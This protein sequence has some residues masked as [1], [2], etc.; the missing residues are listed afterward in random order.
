MNRLIHALK[1]TERSRVRPVNDDENP[2]VVS[3]AAMRNALDARQRAL[4]E[5]VSQLQTDELAETL[6][7][8]VADGA[9]VAAEQDEIMSL[10]NELRAQLDDVQHAID[11]IDAGTYGQ[12]EVC[13]EP[14]DAERLEAMPAARHCRIHAA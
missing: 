14:I 10:A 9:Q 13:H 7:E 2:D 5:Q 12:C 4:Q 6:D 8:H 1:H 11:N 3:D